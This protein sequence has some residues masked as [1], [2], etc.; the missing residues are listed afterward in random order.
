MQD[1]LD[2]KLFDLDDVTEEREKNKVEIYNEY[3]RQTNCSIELD[4]DIN[5]LINKLEQDINYF[6]YQNSPENYLMSTIKP[7]RLSKESN[8]E[9]KLEDFTLRTSELFTPLRDSKVA[10]INMKS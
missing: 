5:S 7:L 6:Q 9:D 2:L 1:D 8:E 4:A 10:S 3:Q